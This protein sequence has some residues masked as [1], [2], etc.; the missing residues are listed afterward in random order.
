MLIIWVLAAK[1]YKKGIVKGFFG[2]LSFVLS[3]IVTAIIYKPVSDYILSIPVVQ[4]K[5]S[6][7]GDKISALIVPSQQSAVATLPI[8]FQKA[9]LSASESANEAIGSSVTNILVSVLCI[10]AI[11]LLVKLSFRLLEGVFEVLMK[12]P[13][14]NLINRAGG[15]ICGIITSVMVLWIIL[16]CVVLFAGTAVFAPV[17]EAIQ[18]TELL[19]YFYNNNLLITM[20][21]K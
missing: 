3:G 9:A 18:D 14:L 20:I 7:I 17:N 15:M 12:L 1:G 6:I 11:Y 10:V 2:V 21:I 16:A 13:V 4:D 5:L 19:K 8:W